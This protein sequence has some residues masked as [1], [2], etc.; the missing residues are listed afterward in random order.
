MKLFRRLSKRMPSHH[1]IKE[2][3]YAHIFGDSLKQAELWSFNRH[4]VSK[5]V[6]VGLFCAFLPMPFET[7]VA[8]FMAIALR[9]NL[10]FAIGF[11]WVSN[12][13]TWVPIYTPCY[14]LGSFILQIEPIP[15]QDIS[16]LQFG[17]HYVALWLGCLIVGTGLSLASHYLINQLWRLNVRQAWQERKENRL[18]RQQQNK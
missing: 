3:R 9:G 14:K 4:S 18:K 13:I 7:V 1:D 12:P 17:W 15:L 5:G 6:A 16:I 10:P 11:V 2:H 8:M